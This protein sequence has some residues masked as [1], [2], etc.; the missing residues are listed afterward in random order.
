MRPPF[1]SDV[2]VIVARGWRSMLWSIA[3]GRLGVVVGDLYFVDPRPEAGQEGAERGVRLEL[4]LFDREPLKGSIYSATP[5]RVDR[6]LWRVDLLESVGSVPG[7][8]ERAHHH[9][10]FAGW[11]PGRR[12]F[13]EELSAQPVG[14]LRAQLAEPAAVLEEAGEETTAHAADIDALRTAAPLITGI[15]E[16]LLAEVAAGRAGVAPDDAGDSVRASWL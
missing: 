12:V 8:I 6:P 5:I 16:H 13:V 3:F 14:W 9:P 1:V 10:R 15:V 2:H 7:S 4:R 11:E